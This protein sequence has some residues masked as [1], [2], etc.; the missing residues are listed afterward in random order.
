MR[1]GLKL[2]QLREREGLVPRPQDLASRHHAPSQAQEHNAPIMS[3]TARSASH[4]TVEQQPL[5]GAALVQG[6]ATNPPLPT[7]DV[8]GSLPPGGDGEEG[9]EEVRA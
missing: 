4:S 3:S 8:V 5:A 7:S 2:A 1:K 6:S 9:R